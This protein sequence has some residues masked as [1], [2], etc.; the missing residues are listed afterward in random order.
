MSSP[1][2]PPAAA[3]NAAVDVNYPADSVIVSANQERLLLPITPS[4]V[5]ESTSVGRTNQ[6]RVILPAPNENDSIV[7]SINPE[8]V[9]LPALD[10]AS[11]YE[12]HYE[13]QTR[14]APKQKI[15]LILMYSMT[16]I[17]DDFSLSS[18]HET[19]YKEHNIH[20][21][22]P[23]KPWIKDEIKRLN[24]RATRLSA[25]TLGE[26]LELL[27]TTHAD[28]LTEGCRQ[29]IKKKHGEIFKLFSKSIQEK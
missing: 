15:P 18:L 26:L 3:I 23:R 29:F 20:T 1:D 4:P 8:G 11:P 27:A 14:T 16:G 13:D 25:A 19:P 21:I 12:K 5:Y 10:N 6:R 22:K 28:H 7:E 24:P 2:T 17:V 9:T